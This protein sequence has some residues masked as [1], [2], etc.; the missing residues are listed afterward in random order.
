MTYETTVSEVGG[1]LSERHR[2]IL[3]LIVEGKSNKEIADELKIKTGTVKQHMFVLFRKLGVSSRAKAVL[4]AEQFLK[5][6]SKNNGAE[7]KAIK[8]SKFAKA[9]E[10]EDRYDWRLVSA[11]AVTIPEEFAFA[12][13]PEEVL[14]R[15]HFL[16]DLQA[17]FNRLVSAYDGTSSMLPDGGMLAWFGHPIAHL[18]DAERASQV[19]QQLQQWGDSYAQASSDPSYKPFFGIG[20]G[21]HTEVVA[22]NTSHLYG[23]ESFRKA[24][25]LSRNAQAL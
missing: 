15:D 8:K 11:V 24:S 9:L 25:T 21:S 5:I 4:V 18:D 17:Y 10:S 20:V 2:E 3:S 7:R 13:N 22:G 19:A 14:K 16:N 12:G 1:P 6:S 23:A